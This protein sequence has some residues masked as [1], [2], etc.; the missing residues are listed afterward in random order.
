MVGKAVIKLGSFMAIG[1]T[2]LQNYNKHWQRLFARG[3]SVLITITTGN[4][5]GA[6]KGA[7]P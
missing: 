2:E 7:R 3:Q 5:R 4:V 6:A 1:M